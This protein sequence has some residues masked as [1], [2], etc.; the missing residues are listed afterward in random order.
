MDAI[1]LRRVLISEEKKFCNCIRSNERLGA[2]IKNIEREN[3]E[4]KEH[5]EPV[6]RS[7]VAELFLLLLRDF[8]QPYPEKQSNERDMKQI[9]LIAPALSKIHLNFAEK[10]SVEEL[11]NECSISKYHFCR[12]FR[13]VMGMTVVQYVTKYRVDV[14]EIML[15]NGPDSINEVA[16]KC[17]F[18]DES[19]F[20]RCYKKV[21]GLAPGKAIKAKF[22]N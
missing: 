1:D 17:G 15:K 13:Q 14:A 18:S 5:Y 10:V 8:L 2:I 22:D 4:K 21:K 19:Y 20:Y 7:L 12:V 16:Y 11:A 9:K 6:I 3:R